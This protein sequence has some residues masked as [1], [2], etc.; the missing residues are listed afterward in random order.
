MPKAP[1]APKA[2][3]ADKLFKQNRDRVYADLK[4]QGLTDAEIRRYISTPANQQVTGMTAGTTGMGGLQSNQELWQIAKDQRVSQREAQG[5]YYEPSAYAV[6][7]T[8][9]AP[10]AAMNIPVNAAASWWKNQ[11]YTGTGADSVLASSANALIPELASGEQ[12]AISKWMGENF[13]AFSD[14][15]TASIG[16]TVSSTQTRNYFFSKLRAVKAKANLEE[17]ARAAG[18]DPSAL[19]PGY[20]FLVSVTGLLDKYGGDEL[21]AMSRASYAQMQSE[22][23]KL[24]SGV[25]SSYVE[26]GRSFLN[27]T[28]QGSQLRSSYVASGRTQSG[29]PNS[30]LFV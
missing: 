2:P 8:I 19:G 26:L 1:K 11:V 22:F 9:E 4:S 15:A 23:D 14:Y 21:N 27:P 6:S 13:K 7:P 12:R 5:D 25:D 20:Q 16:D 30:R 10:T 24:S 3:V 18:A 17:M 29:I 28:S